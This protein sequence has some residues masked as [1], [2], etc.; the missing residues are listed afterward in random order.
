MEK[1]DFL[2]YTDLFTKFVVGVIPENS[3][4]KK[5]AIAA[6]NLVTEAVVLYIKENG[7]NYDPANPAPVV[8]KV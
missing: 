2:S 5:L 1:K 3:K 4:W 8:P 6:Q 7:G